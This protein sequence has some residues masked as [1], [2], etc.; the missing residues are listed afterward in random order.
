MIAQVRV[1]FTVKLTYCSILW[2]VETQQV[3]FWDSFDFISMD[4]YVP[5]WNGSGPIPTESA[6]L[7][8]WDLVANFKKMRKEESKLIHSLGCWTVNLWSLQMKNKKKRR[9]EKTNIPFKKLIWY[10]GA[11][12]NWHQAQPN[13]SS[14]FIY[15]SELGYFCVF[16]F[17]FVFLLCCLC[18][19]FPTFFNSFPPPF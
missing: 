8:V 11:V 18:V 19:F 16:F 15:L 7:S 1:N 6:M 9:K 5:F 3:T 17:L 12:N 14:K 2:P 10:Y 13:V 4:T